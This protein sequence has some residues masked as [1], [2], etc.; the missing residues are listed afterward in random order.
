MTRRARVRTPYVERLWSTLSARDWAVIDTV[1]RLRLVSG[2]QLERLHFSELSLRSQPVVRWRVLKRLVD[3]RVLV[4]LERRVGTALRGSDKL[5]YALDTAGQRLARMRVNAD[6]RDGAV[7]RPRVPGERFFTHTLAVSEI[8]VSLVERSRVGHFDLVAFLAEP[9]AWVPDRLGGWLKPD[10]FA[11]LRAGDV[12]D[13]W[14]IEVDMATES[15]PYIRRQLRAYLGFVERGQLG[16]DGVVPRVLIGVSHK[17]KAR[18]QAR[19]TAMQRIVNEL[20]GPADY[21]FYVTELSSAA[22]A[23]E[24]E[25]T[26]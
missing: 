12:Y 19:Q 23:M 18:L 5:C 21:M 9:A 22:V 17:D 6:P 26:N 13:Y 10:A 7:R 25:L 24:H 4:A 14:W 11:K 1:Y 8:Y 2:W 15:L 3:A 16:P 20:P